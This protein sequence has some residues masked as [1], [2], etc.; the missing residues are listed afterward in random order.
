MFF[1][2]R[3]LTNVQRVLQVGSLLWSGGRELVDDLNVVV[4]VVDDDVVLGGGRDLLGG[5]GSNG[6]RR[7]RLREEPRR[8]RLWSGSWPLS[9]PAS[10]AS[11]VTWW[12]GPPAAG[13]PGPWPCR[14]GGEF[15]RMSQMMSLLMIATTVPTTKDLRMTPRTMVAIQ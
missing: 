10:S 7:E 14:G 4:D 11:W 5:R 1:L 9:S 12:P 15:E 6:E 8:L 3:F 13:C 2:F